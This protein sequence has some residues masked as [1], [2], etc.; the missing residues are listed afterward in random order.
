MVIG[1]G[2]GWLDEEDIFAAHIF[3][4][5]CEDFLIAK[6]FYINGGERYIE[7]IGDAPGERFI[8]RAADQFHAILS[9]SRA[10][11]NMPIGSV[12][13]GAS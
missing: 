11:G 10:A 5:F 9:V 1:R 7:N 8:G 6:P 13:L 2:R 4:D 3:I 12:V